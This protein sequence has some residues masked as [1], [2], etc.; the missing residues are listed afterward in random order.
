MSLVRQPRPCHYHVPPSG[1]HSLPCTLSCTLSLC[2]AHTLSCTGS[3]THSCTESH[4]VSHTLSCT[5]VW[6][7]ADTISVSLCDT[8]PDT[9]WC[10]PLSLSPCTW[11][12][13]E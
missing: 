11:C 1:T 8:P 7:W 4:T 9:L 3:H 6:W 5:P 10:R 13:T 12:P 2:M